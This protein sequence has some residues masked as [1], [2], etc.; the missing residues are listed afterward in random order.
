VEKDETPQI[1]NPKRRNGESRWQRF[2]RKRR[3]NSIRN[4]SDHAVYT[5]L[6]LFAAVLLIAVIAFL[7]TRGVS[8]Q[9]GAPKGLELWNK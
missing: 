4:S 9:G 7:G 3:M 8:F 2:W 1:I 5:A 6:A